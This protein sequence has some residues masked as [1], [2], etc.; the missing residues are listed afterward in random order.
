MIEFD[1][2]LNYSQWVIRNEK[3]ESHREERRWDLKII[4]KKRKQNI[5]KFGLRS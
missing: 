3:F 2:Y 1:L 5:G 4:I